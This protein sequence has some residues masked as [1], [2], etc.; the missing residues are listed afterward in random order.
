M[1]HISPYGSLRGTGV[2]FA[3]PRGIH[4][5][6]PIS[7]DGGQTKKEE[8]CLPLG[9][10]RAVRVVTSLRCLSQRKGSA[11]LRSNVDREALG[12]AASAS[13]NAARTYVS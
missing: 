1:K 10:R 2:I 3:A 7:C 12:V 8:A 4:Q 9:E 6:P 5:T 13:V 11:A